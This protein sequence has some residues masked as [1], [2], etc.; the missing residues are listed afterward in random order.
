MRD[1]HRH[2]VASASGTC[3]GAMRLAGRAVAMGYNVLAVDSDTVVLDDWY[4]RVKTVRQAGAAACMRRVRRT[5][6]Q[7]GTHPALLHVEFLYS[8]VTELACSPLLG[9]SAPAASAV[10]HQHVQSERERHDN[11]RCVSVCVYE[12]IVWHKTG[13][14]CAGAVGSTHTRPHA[15]C[16]PHNAW[17]LPDAPSLKP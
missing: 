7:T 15:S 4:R 12:Y 9:Y 10:V 6:T 2:D 8:V 13:L 3:A 11:Q 1:K 14:G 5:G 16:A 17:L